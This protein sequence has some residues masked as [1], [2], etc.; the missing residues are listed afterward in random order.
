M[1][2]LVL[3]CG[4]SSAKFQ[5]IET[6]L[7]AIKDSSERMLAKGI[8]ERIGESIS[9]K[10]IESMG[11]EPYRKDEP[12][13]NHTIAIQS[14]LDLL[15][16]PVYGIIKDKSE[17]DAVGHRM[18]HGGETF[19]HSCMITEKVLEKIKECIPLAPLHNP[20]NI[21]GYEIS[22]EL[23]GDTPHVAVFDTAFHQTMPPSSFIYALP[24][25]YYEKKRIRRYG[26]HG[27]SHRYVARR[28]GRL[29]NIPK[30][31]FNV[32][33]VHL[34]NGASIAAVKKGRVIDTSMGFTPLEGLV[35][36]TRCGDIDPA[37]LMFLLENDHIDVNGLNKILNKKSGLL[38]ISGISNDMRELQ[39]AA[40]EGNKR[41][42]L[43][44]D[45]FCYRIKKYIG[46]YA[47]A[48]GGVDYVAFTAGIGENSIIVRE[49]CCEGL[50]G[51]GAIIDLKRNEE[52]NRKEGV[53]STK[54]SKVKLCIIPTNEEMVI[55]HDTV[56]AV[57]GLLSCNNSK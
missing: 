48:M 50:E 38:G 23:L 32:I 31:S 10:K 18:V 1:K 36:G 51:I 8:V 35:M 19:T 2:V 45:I 44:I 57:E 52:L 55:A 17:I 22:K 26:F 6:S 56:E 49:K 42:E 43:A 29:F 7:Q 24:Y 37:I 53:F 13:P 40:E 25:E 14:I 27:T 30:D 41:A 33:T 9:I 54:D 39:K 15:A 20:H 34:G 5:L 28:I 21:K 12:I 16:D 11:K 46:S 3:N 47:A 4:S